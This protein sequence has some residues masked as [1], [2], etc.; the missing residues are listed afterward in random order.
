MKA[1][2]FQGRG[3]I[4]YRIALLLLLV[5]SIPTILFIGVVHADTYVEGYHRKDGTYVKPHYRSSPDDSYNNNWSVKPNYNPY[6]GK[7]GT[8]NPTWNDKNPYID[9]YDESPY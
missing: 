9:G 1:G 6:T 4:S 5:I 3:G 7:R 2:R 8:K